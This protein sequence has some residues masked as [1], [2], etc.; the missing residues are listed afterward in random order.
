MGGT[1]APSFGAAQ[2]YVGGAPV[3]RY[4]DGIWGEYH[5]GLD[6]LVP[7]GTPV[8]APAA[9]TVLFAGPLA[10]TG[11]TVIVDHGQS[12]VSVFYH[13]ASTP[14]HHGD[15]IE[16]GQALGV[17]G[18]TGIAAVPHLHWGVYVSGVAVDPRITLGF[19]E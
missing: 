4:V 5:R 9:G 18:E 1:A 6:Y 13:L 17:A 15:S 3:E 2:T 10:L 14:V 11:E 7:P 12:V 19:T 16:A 8:A